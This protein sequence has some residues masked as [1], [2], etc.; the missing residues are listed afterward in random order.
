MGQLEVR[1]RAVTGTWG[2]Y[3]HA[4]IVHSYVDEAITGAMCLASK[5]DRTAL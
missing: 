4:Y 5:K 2:V 3:D 1:T